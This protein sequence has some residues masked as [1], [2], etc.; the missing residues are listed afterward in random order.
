MRGGQR[1]QVSVFVLCTQFT[2]CS[3]KV[4]VQKYQ[5]KS[6]NTDTRCGRSYSGCESRG[7]K[8]LFGAAGAELIREVCPHTTCLSRKYICVL[9]LLYVS[10][11]RWGG[12]LARCVLMLLYM[13][14]HTAC[15]ALRP[16]VYVSAYCYRCVRILLYM[17]PHTAIYLSSYCYI[18][19]L[20]LVYMCPHTTFPSYNYMC[21]HWAI[22]VL[23]LYTYYCVGEGGSCV[24]TGC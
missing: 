24:G 2:C 12:A 9:M 17:C 5:Y 22:C 8:Q 7:G 10:S 15:P 21:P 18:C 16:S 4:P 19:V 1:L 23:I 20:I 11:C 3:T 14:P 13:C 6:T